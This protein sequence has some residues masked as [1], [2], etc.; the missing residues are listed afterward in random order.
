M[1]E[2][3]LDKVVTESGG[4]LIVALVTTS[5]VDAMRAMISSTELVR[6]ALPLPHSR[7]IAVSKEAI[8]IL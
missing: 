3:R 2:M 1:R 6:G 8:R 4:Q 5:N 7:D